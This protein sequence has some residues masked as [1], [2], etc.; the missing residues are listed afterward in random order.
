MNETRLE[1]I[2]ERI[3]EIENNPQKYQNPDL[4]LSGLNTLIDNLL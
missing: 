2:L 3:V 4:L 1:K